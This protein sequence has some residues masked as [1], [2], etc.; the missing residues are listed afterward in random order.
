MDEHLMSQD[1]PSPHGSGTTV[2]N[3]DET[4]GSSE[5]AARPRPGIRFYVSWVLAIALVLCALGAFVLA[6]NRK[7]GRQAQALAQQQQ[8]GPRVLV[9]P[10]L[11]PPAL[12]SLEL[13]AT[14]HGYT[15]TPIYAK[16]SGYLK[17]IKVD[18][19][20]RVTK[21]QV[22][23][24]LESPELD[25]QLANARATFDLNAIT[26]RRNQT[27]AHESIVPRQ[28]A[29]ESHNNMLAAKA[30]V[31]QLQALEGYKLITA[32]FT[33]VV[34][35]R[36]VDPG[37]LIP[38]TTTS[39]SNTPIL[40]LATLSPLRVYTDVPQALA[41]FIR[42]GDPAIVS[43][44]EYPGRSFEGRITR[45][46]EALTAATRT[47]L[48][49]VDLPNREQLLF[50]GMYAKVT[51]KVSAPSAERM[52]SDDALVFRDGKPFVPVVRDNRL[53]L[54]PVTLGF[55]DGV[56]VEVTGD[57]SDQDLVAVNVGQAVHDGEQV[58]PISQTPH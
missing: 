1:R 47:M 6:R 34:T 33:G 39:N 12:R 27:L 13:P 15:E 45:H 48:V 42:D 19:G 8:R 17:N 40:A 36:Y 30:N 52:V 38:Q 58:Q 4:R 28:T 53:Q 37:A 5:T 41:P 21:G 32:P 24:I 35:A 43:V 51:L 10:I 11:H 46:P 31:D 22:L 26:D 23:A 54:V 25:Q 57:L 44:G 49:E 20:V 9:Q 50:P 3:T 16:V 29:D 14:M 56:N 55:D 7:L 2:A 18:K